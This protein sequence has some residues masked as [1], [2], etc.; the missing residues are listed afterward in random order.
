MLFKIMIFFPFHKECGW[1]N[2]KKAIF[3][4][5]QMLMGKEG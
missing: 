2:P 4:I 3:E 5:M 1:R